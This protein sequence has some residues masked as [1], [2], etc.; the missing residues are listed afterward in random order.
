VSAPSVN[1]NQT[2]DG[3]AWPWSATVPTPYFSPVV[4][5]G[6]ARGRGSP[7]SVLV[8]RV[9]VVESVGSPSSPSGS[10]VPQPAR[11]PTQLAVSAASIVRRFGHGDGN[12]ITGMSLDTGV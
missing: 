5:R 4:H 11:P 9:P 1:V 8:D 12:G 10:P 7:P 2:R 3:S 6:S